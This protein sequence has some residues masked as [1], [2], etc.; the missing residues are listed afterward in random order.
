MVKRTVQSLLIGFLVAGSLW[1]AD[2][3]FVG[4]WKLNAP[5]S[6]LTDEMKVKAVGPNK[7]ALDFGG[8]TWETVVAD[9]TDQPGGFGTTL[10]VT[11]DGPDTWK[12][13]RKKD[14]H[15]LVTGIWK[16][17][18]DGKTLTDNFTANQ[19][20]G[21]TFKLDYVYHRA[22][23][24]SGFPG[25][26]ESTSE[27]VDS[28]FEIQIQPYEDDG[29]SFNTPAQKTAQ[30]MKFDGKDYPTVGP[31][32]PAGSVSSGRRVNQ[33]TLEITDKTEDK[34]TDTRLVE[35]SPD[36]KTLTM[37]VHPAGQGKPNILVFDRE[38]TRESSTH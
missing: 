29:L 8:G 15:T 21:S 25:T 4:M 17:S 37:T 27:K 2:D 22:A 11:A 16:L 28:V 13:V 12:V 26:W 18:Q 23:G 19:A 20:D 10:S 14:G 35:L 34:V 3:P 9:G 24:T 38:E 1:A 30:N 31:N 7:Y 6:T 36:L 5:K 32:V 33:S